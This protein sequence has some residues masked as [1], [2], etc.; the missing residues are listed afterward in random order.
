M[1]TVTD[2]FNRSSAGSLGSP[3]T[4]ETSGAWDTDGTH[5]VGGSTDGAAFL[6]LSSAD[7]VL[8]SVETSQAGTYH[9]VLMRKATTSGTLRDD[10]YEHFYWGPFGF[11]RW[12]K[13]VGGSATNLG[14]Y[15]YSGYTDVSMR[16]MVYGSSATRLAFWINGVNT[17]TVI[18]D[19]SSPI[20]TGNYCGIYQEGTGS[21]KFNS[22]TARDMDDAWT[23]LAF[24]G[25]SGAG[26][27]SG[28]LFDSFYSNVIVASAVTAGGTGGTISDNKSNSW[29]SAVDKNDGATNRVT[30]YHVLSPTVGAGHTFTWTGG[31]VEA[32]DVQ[33]WRCPGGA[34][35]LDQTNGTTSGTQPGSITPTADDCLLIAG[36]AGGTDASAPTIDSG[37]TVTTSRAFTTSVCL[38]SGMAYLVQDTAAAINPT[39][40]DTGAN[41]IASYKPP[42]GGGGGTVVPL[43]DGEMLVGGFLEMSGG[44]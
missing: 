12:R 26:T 24:V 11:F 34:P 7:Q 3:W 5:A 2:L 43:F 20:T 39:W 6:L 28:A 15:T 35:T 17:D 25:K 31:A 36:A 22:I 8:D 41:A 38:N 1:T 14:D 16:R 30:I 42:G 27:S 37:F 19:S 44:V 9:G 10:T 29:T 4:A 33:A 40:S 32:I 13:V 18:V 23:M 21:A